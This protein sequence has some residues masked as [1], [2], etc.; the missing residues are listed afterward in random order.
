MDYQLKKNLVSNIIYAY[1]DDPDSTVDP[2]SFI[3]Y[4]I[5]YTECLQD[6]IE[7]KER[8]SDKNRIM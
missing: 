7:E 4:P 5:K 6:I 2:F 8:F 3:K 1:D